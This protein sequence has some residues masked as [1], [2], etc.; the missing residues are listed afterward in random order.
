MFITFMYSTSDVAMSC[1]CGKI[2]SL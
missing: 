1:S 2:Y